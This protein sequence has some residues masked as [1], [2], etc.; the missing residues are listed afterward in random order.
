M[1]LS[2]AV[3]QQLL[4]SARKLR[5]GITDASRSTAAGRRRLGAFHRIPASTRRCRMPYETAAARE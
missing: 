1:R 2:T 5:S 3:D 4:N